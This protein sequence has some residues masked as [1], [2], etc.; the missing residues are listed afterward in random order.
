MASAHEV[1]SK[2]IVSEISPIYETLSWLV[3]NDQR[4]KAKRFYG[5]RRFTK[6]VDNYFRAILNASN[7]SRMEGGLLESANEFGQYVDEIFKDDRAR[8]L[9]VLRKEAGVAF[10][11]LYKRTRLL[12]K[13][14]TALA[15]S[16][17]PD[18][19]VGI[20]LPDQKSSPIYA[21]VDGGRVILDAGHSLHPLLHKQGVNETRRYLRGELSEIDKALKSS[22]VDRRYVDAFSLLIDLIEF[23]DDAGAI[24]FGLHIRMVSQLSKKI[25]DEMSEILSIQVSSTLTHGAYFASQYKDWMEFL[26]NARDY[27]PRTLVESEMS[28]SLTDVSNVLRN[29]PAVVDERIP[30]SIQVIS[31]MLAGSD[32][33]RM[34]A[35]YAGVRSVENICISAI[36]YSS[37]QA[38]QLLQAAGTKARPAL[39]TMGAAA[40]IILALQV[41]ASFMPVIQNAPE[42]GWILENL[43]HIKNIARVLSGK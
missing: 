28:G 38:K 43:S 5:D 10:S 16:G 12:K 18:D 30:Q 27:E 37:D 41:I 26:Q 20:N 11:Q 25:E 15:V 6:I 33:D 42:L 2:Q 9:T 23:K 21:K 34:N 36:K 7:T 24:S 1:I 17:D 13:L 35:V 22:N 4:M 29:N 3:R 31:T 40:I 8:I 19:D 14:L 32:E 39:V